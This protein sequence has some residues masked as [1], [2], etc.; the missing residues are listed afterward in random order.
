MGEDAKVHSRSSEVSET[1]TDDEIEELVSRSEKDVREF[2]ERL[3]RNRQFASRPYCRHSQKDEPLP[4][5]S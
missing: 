2:F 3:R 4:E 5:D 1:T